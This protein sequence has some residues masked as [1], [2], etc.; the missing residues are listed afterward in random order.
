MLAQ[1]AY[2]H[3]AITEEE[4]DSLIEHLESKYEYEEPTIGFRE[5]NKVDE[6]FRKCN[7]AWISSIKEEKLVRLLWH[8]VNCANK[9][10]FNF[11]LNFINQIQFTKYEGDGKYN[12]HHDVDWMA[13][14]SY[15]RKLSISILL[16]DGYEGGRFE[17]DSTLPQLPEQALEKGSIIVF[18]SFYTHRVTPITT[19]VRYSLVTWVEGPKWR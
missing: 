5:S 2:F 13:Q 1:W 11:D 17:F 3:K 15:H 4:C 6:D 9:D 18:P 19:G 8:Y 16:D 10:F 12:W 7:I 14:G